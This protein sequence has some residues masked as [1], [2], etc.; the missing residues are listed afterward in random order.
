MIPQNPFYSLETLALFFE[1]LDRDRLGPLPAKL[2][3]H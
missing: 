2:Y 1:L 3:Q